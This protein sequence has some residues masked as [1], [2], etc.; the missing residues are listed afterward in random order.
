VPESGPRGRAWLA[1]SLAVFALLAAGMFAAATWSDHEATLDQGWNGAENTA[2]LLSGHAERVLRV[3][4]ISTARMAPLLE[5]A[6]NGVAAPDLTALLDQAPELRALALRDGAGRLLASAIGP[7]L[8]A[9]TLPTAPDPATLLALGGGANTHLAP[10]PAGPSGRPPGFLWTRALRQDG[11]LL[12]MAQAALSAEDFAGAATGLALGPDARLALVGADGATVLRWPNLPDSPAEPERDGHAGRRMETGADGVQRLVAWHAASDMSVTAVAAISRDHVLAPFRARRLRNGLVFALSAMLAA[13]LGGAALRAAR[14]ERTAR[15]AAEERGAALTISLTEREGLLASV[16]EGE[17]R[18]RLAEEA[19]GI[20][21]WEWDLA[22][23]RLM[24]GGSVF[25]DWGLPPDRRLRAG[26]AL[27]AVAPEDRAALQAAAFAARQGAGPLEGEFRLALPGRPRWVAL[28]AELR[29]DSLG[30]PRRLLG[31]ALEVTQ[32][33][34]AAEALAEANALLERRVAARTGALADANARLR[35]GEARFRGIFDASFQLMALLSPDG[36]V[37]EANAALRRLAAADGGTAHDPVQGGALWDAAC[38]P[39]ET[40]I[41]T[42]LREA[43]AAAAEGR[44]IRREVALPGPRGSAQGATRALDL[45]VTPVRDED[46]LVSLL[47]VEGRDI[48]DLKS[49]QAL[50]LEAQKMDTL[51]QLTGGVAHDFNNLLMAVLGNL[52]LA[53]RRLGAVLAPEVARHLDA[54]VQG[55]ERGAQLTQR[56]LAFAR[57][58]DLSP[59]SVDL[60]AL[61]AGMQ[62]LLHR[63]AGPLTR[64]GI[65]APPGLPPALV[66]AHA[67]ELALMNLAVNARDAMPEGG[68]LRFALAEVRGPIPGQPWAPGLRAGRYLRI[69][70][71]DTGAGMDAATLARAVEPFFSTK[72]PGQGTGLGLSMVHGLAHQSGGALAIDSAPGAGTVARLWLPVSDQAPMAAPAAEAAIDAALANRPGS[73]RVLVV[74]D[75]ALVLESTA[76]MLEELGY[77]PVRA[78]SGEAA[79]AVLAAE[80]CLVAVL[81]DHAMPGMTGTA[82]AEQIAARRPGLPVILATGHAGAATGSVAVARLGKPY[83]LAQLASVLAGARGQKAAE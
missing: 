69:T 31:I 80:S 50:L 48:S 58:Q 81:T 77:Q 64:V 6:Q 33:R 8:L 30:R 9:L 46:G 38:W 18:L 47:V 17:A 7:A 82:L 42:T 12:G 16:R 36:T 32:R 22:E 62:D 75:E 19:G 13:A 53:R 68:A 59:S 79:L 29:R 39:A 10:L 37:L 2:A 14:R 55:A 35:E 43:V 45:S 72:P 5:A 24:L 1:A 54:A 15:Q 25:Q 63:S 76:A 3:A 34:Q 51:G 44:F 61:L 83:G 52:A 26:L 57:R 21:L 56:L 73:G 49:A 27:R 67:L 60:R 40:T 28:R 71:A 78:E 74:D 11:R 20:G 65:E 23:G 4:D 70:V 41:R 66:D